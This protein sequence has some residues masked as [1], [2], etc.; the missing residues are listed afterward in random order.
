MIIRL[1]I[2][3]HR[4]VNW[5]YIPA[6]MT[7]TNQLHQCSHKICNIDN[8]FSFFGRKFFHGFL[9]C[10]YKSYSYLWASVRTLFLKCYTL[11]RQWI[12]VILFGIN[13]P[14]GRNC[15][16]SDTFFLSLVMLVLFP[17]LNHKNAIHK[18]VL[19]EKT[20]GYCSWLLLPIHFKHSTPRCTCKKQ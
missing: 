15:F 12:L 9:A 8:S 1:H 13:R 17:V 7:A 5:I 11:Y 10:L 3:M 20:G 19:H 14:L 18:H 2:L 6:R 4:L 16:Y